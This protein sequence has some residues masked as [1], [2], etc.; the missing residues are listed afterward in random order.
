MKSFW[1]ALRETGRLFSSQWRLWIPFLVTAIAEIV[2]LLLI[3]LAPQPP[4][5]RLLAPP[6]RYVFGERVLHYPAHLWFLFQ[7]MR[8]T[9]LVATTLL[10]AF[11]TGVA[12]VMVAQTHHGVPLSLREALVSRQVRYGRV[13]VL[14]LITW[15]VAKGLMAALASAAPQS[16]RTVWVALAAAVFIQTVFVYAIPAAVYEGSAWWKAVGQGLRET[17]RYPVSTLIAVAVPSALLIAFSLVVTPSAVAGWMDQ[18]VPEVAVGF[19]GARLLVSTLTDVL[20]T[21]MVAHLWWAHRAPQLAAQPVI[22]AGATQLAHAPRPTPR[23]PSVASALAVIM[24]LALT[25]CSANYN[26][27]RLFWKADQLN[28]PIV[29]DPLHATPQQLAAATHAFERVIQ[30][31]PGTKWAAHA[32][33]AIG[34][35]YAIQKQYDKA[36]ETYALVPQNYHRYQDLC[37]EARLLIAK[38]YEVEQKWDEALA[39]Y[40]QISTYHPLTTIGLEAPLYI[41]KL[42]TDHHREAE[43]TEAYRRAVQFYIKLVP[44]A[45]TPEVTNQVKSYLELAYQGTGEWDK[46]IAMLQELSNNQVGVSR[47]LSLLKLGTIYQTKLGNVAKAQAIYQALLKEFPDNPFGKAAKKRL[48]QLGQPS[49]SAADDS[50]GVVESLDAAGA[51]VGSD[52]LAP[53]APPTT[54][55]TTR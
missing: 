16:T 2:L 30:K 19:A 23:A 26:G 52:R 53:S 37:L 31:A 1:L 11:M 27:E 14:W 36:R 28:K 17:A 55:A 47:A 54:S 34:L 33:L 32:Q 41:A 35:L 46:A 9:H 21:I 7:V 38:T 25:G 24:A 42:Y 5:S 10:G 51:I 20:M 43:A 48:E 4:F 18:A 6:I 15:G 44:D 22:G 40:D 29:K 49:G 3:W 39:A 45:P 12:C 8:H 13:L 50:A